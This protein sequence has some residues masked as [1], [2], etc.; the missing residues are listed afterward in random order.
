MFDVYYCPRAVGRFQKGRDATVLSGFLDFLHRRGHAR[1]TVQQYVRAAELFL[2]WLRRRRMPLASVD[3]TT[4]R[5]FACRRRSAQKP[6]HSAHAA[7]RHL[8][9]HLKRE[10][11][12]PAR[13]AAPMSALERLVAEYDAHL[14]KAC[15]L[16]AATRR[17]RRRYAR[18]FMQFVFGSGRMDWR[19]TRP[20]HVH[21]FIARYGVD[22][23][24][25]AAQVAAVSLRSFLRWLQ[26]RGRVTA[27]LIAA[28]PRFRRWRLTSL[29]TVM[30]QVQLR[31]F[32]ASFNSSRPSG[33]RDYAM[34]LCMV[35]LGLRVAEVAGLQIDDLDISAGTLRLSPGK[36]RRIRVLPMPR[37]VWRAVVDY[38]RRDRP[39]TDDRGLFLRHRVPIGMAVTRELIRGVVRR[40]YA[41]VPGCESWTGTHPL[42]HTAATRL[43]QAGADLKR[44]AD[45]LG[46]LS[47]DTTAIY[48]KAD[49]GRLA[50]VAL[51]WPGGEE[52][53]S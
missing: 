30:S 4:V 46:H 35:D 11:R 42:R 5:Q 44:V 28:I 29:P 18:E 2:R 16:S 20:H 38:V 15:G 41:K 33:R 36:S 51:P 12:M 6:R 23:R 43:Q 49:L 9:R 32:L 10:G 52:V 13:T 7:L 22:G 45:I 53:Q 26:F 34:A 48:T 8:L 25:A 17:Y 37:R 1:N 24:I 3:E 19:R 14:D 31:S 39:K 40:A 27:R 50:Q 47:L 21:D